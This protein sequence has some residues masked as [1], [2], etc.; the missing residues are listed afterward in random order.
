M[1]YQEIIYA[2]FAGISCKVYDDF[3]DNNLIKSD[4]VKEILKGSHWILITLVSMNDFN[5]SVIWYLLCFANYIA[6]PKEWSP[7]YE[8]SGIYLYPFLI[9]LNYHTRK[10][11]TMSDIIVCILLILSLG[12]EPFII[13]EEVSYRKLINRFSLFLSLCILVY[14]S[15]YFN[16]SNSIQKILYYYI[17]YLFISLCFQVYILYTEKLEGTNSSIEYSLNGLS[18]IIFNSRRDSM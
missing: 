1:E 17:G 3:N 8:T 14:F 16:I 10:Y 18:D 6:N 7:P 13:T 2:L 11:L 9:L 4:L 15:S 5:F 12:I